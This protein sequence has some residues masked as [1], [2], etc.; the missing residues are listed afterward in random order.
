MRPILLQGHDRAITQ[1]KYNREGDLIFSAAKDKSPSIWYSSN[2][3]RLGTFDGHDGVVWC[4]DVDW[5]SSK[6][7]TGSGDMTVR[8]WD[9]ESGK[10]LNT[11]DRDSSVRTCLFSYSGNMVAYSTDRA[12]NKP[13]EIFFADVRDPSQL[14]ESVTRTTV[15]DND[16]VT[17]ILWGSL[18]ETVVTGHESGKLTQWDL[19]TNKV[20]T[21]V[22]EHTGN[23]NDM[24]PSK[25]GT[26]F[27]TASK[28]HT[29]KLFDTESVECMKTYKTD[30]PVNSACISPNLEHV[31]VG[32]GQEAMEVTTTATRQGKFEARFFHL[33]YEEE[34][35]RVKG[36]FG[37][38][39]SIA[40]H[41]GGQQYTS[42]AED[43]F[44]RVH[45]FD[46]DYFEYKFDF[47]A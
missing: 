19:K 40:F 22:S 14:G 15:T 43:G 36:H 35:A 41:P 18:D 24:Q 9:V 30:R 21:T 46:R 2:G 12:M 28:D 32:G 29:S 16:K 31:V 42:G 47:Y 45:N 6:A 23:I 4:V 33:I 5:K 10:C 26:M 8:L 27:I 44:L 38:I 20:V 3:E 11:I 7:L 39:N 34:F 13:C 25:D 17:S 1:V 37:P